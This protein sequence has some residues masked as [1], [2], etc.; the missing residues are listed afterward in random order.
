MSPL[1]LRIS[2]EGANLRLALPREDQHVQ[3]TLIGLGGL[4]GWLPV[5]RACQIGFGM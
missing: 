3:A 1:T 5:L 4:T 2:G